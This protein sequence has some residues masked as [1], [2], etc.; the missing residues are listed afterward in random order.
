MFRHSRFAGAALAL[1]LAC[2]GPA[3]A[4]SD[5]VKKHHALSLIGEPKYPADFKNFDWVN[6]DAPKGGRIRQWAFGSFDTLNHFADAKG[7][8]AAALDLIY[9]RLMTSSPDEP[10]GSYGNVAEWVSYPS[11]YSSAT[12]GLRATARFHDGKPMTPEDVIFSLNTLK[13][14]SGRMGRYYANVVSAE[15]TG[16]SEVKFTFNVTGNRELPLI[17]CELPVLP[18]HYWEGTGANGEPRDLAKS[19]LEIPLGS[20]PYK[21]KELAAGRFI[22]YERVADWWAKDLPANKGQ[23]NF[24][25]IRFNYGSDKSAAFNEFRAGDFDYWPESSAKDWATQ[26]EFDAVR[27]S[28]VVKHEVPIQRIQSMQGFA[29][30]T[31][32]AQFKDPR[33]RQAFNYA[34]NF[35]AANKTLFYDQYVRAR[36]FFGNSELESKGLPQGRE[37]EIL[38][39]VKDQVP[40]EVFTTEWKNPQYSWPPDNTADRRN[41]SEAFKLFAAAGWKLKGKHLVNEKGEQLVAEFLLSNPDFLRIAQPYAKELEDR[42]GV[43][44]SVRMV[45]T[46]QYQRRVDTFD[47]DIVVDS[48]PQSHSPGNEQRSY[49]GSESADRDGSDNAVGI[50]NPAIDKLIEKIIMA[51]DRPELEATTRALDRVLLWNHYVVP[52][53]NAKSDRFAV[54]NKFGKPERLPSQT[55]SFLRVWWFD[56]AAAKKLAEARGQ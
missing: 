39:E 10:T 28:M 47:F 24:D 15:K 27:K 33:V 54:W 32:R 23:W 9:D 51:K 44:T 14:V 6:P 46:S 4:Q 36:S 29:F 1:L 41:L 8:P 34:F 40:P 12:V 35:E 2:G 16:P 48:F 55:A 37:L 43:K 42:F 30:N 19:T 49:W 20:G 21:I 25:E 22:S 38:N 5:G 18:K 11:D 50:K 45:D 53:W 7:R 3:A 17:I 31:R 26:F 13:K 56:Q 52:Q